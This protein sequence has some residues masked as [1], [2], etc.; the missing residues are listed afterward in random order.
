MQNFSQ[1]GWDLEVQG[2]K[3]L[4]L[5][6]H[7]ERLIV[8]NNNNNRWQITSQIS[9]EKVLFCSKGCLFS[10]N[11]STLS[12]STTVLSRQTTWAN[13]HS[14]VYIFLT[15]FLLPR[16]RY[17]RCL[18]HFKKIKNNNNN[19][20]NGICRVLHGCNFRDA[21]GRSDQCSVKA[22]L[23]LYEGRSINKLQN[24]AILLVF[25]I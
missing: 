17:R 7:R 20:N 2:P 6:K 8:I 22:W 14:S 5:S 3:N 16:P 11:D 1:I 4:F 13:G 25:Q 23:D 19:N 18:S 24:N 15:D 12:C 9:R 10:F 21:G